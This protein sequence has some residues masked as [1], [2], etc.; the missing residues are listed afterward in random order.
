[1][2]LLRF[3]FIVILVLWILRLLIRLVMPLIFSNLAKKMQKQASGY[4]APQKKPEGTISVDYMPP[5]NQG[6]TDKLGDFVEY[7]EVK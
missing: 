4:N 3:I 6:K 7:E 2:A 1:M 5:S